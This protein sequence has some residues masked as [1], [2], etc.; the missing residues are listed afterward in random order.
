MSTRKRILINVGLTPCLFGL[1]A[2]KVISNL[3][4]NSVLTFS[5]RP[6]EYLFFFAVDYGIY[7]SAFFALV[8]ILLPGKAKAMFGMIALYISGALGIL[9]LGY[10][11]LGQMM[12]LLFTGSFSSKGLYHFLTIGV[13]A[14]IYFSAATSDEFDAVKSKKN[15]KKS[16]W[17]FLGGNKTTI[18]AE[19]KQCRLTSKSR[20]DIHGSGGQEAQDKKTTPGNKK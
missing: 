7:L 3:S 13:L 5:K 12:I 16:Q 2:L 9:E 18:S 8:T 15:K 1:M 17:I 10:Y 4:M 14:V 19:R 20:G 11:I 6:T